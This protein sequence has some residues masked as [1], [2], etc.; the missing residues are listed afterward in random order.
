MSFPG[1]PRGSA[2]YRRLLWALFAVGIGMFAQLYAPQPILP[3]LAEDLGVSPSSAALTVSM[4]T[5]GLAVCVV[6]LSVLSDRLGR[7]RTITLGLA[8]GTLMGLLTPLAP[9]FELLLLARVLE[10]GLLGAVPAVTLAYLNEEVSRIDAA[11]AAGVYVAGSTIGGL[12]G[13]LIT[14]PLAEAFGWRAGVVA[15]ALLCGMATAAFRV[16]APASRRFTPSKLTLT[17]VTGRLKSVFTRRLVTLYLQGALLMGGFVG[18]Y[19][20]IS[21]RLT[22]DPFR[23]SSTV[24][25]F[26]FLAYLAGTV[27]SSLAGQLTS[28]VGRLPLLLASSAVMA[29][30]VVMTASAHLW[31]VIAGM[32]LTTGGY[33]AAHTTASA[34]AGF[35]AVGARA[36][37]ASVYNVF[38]YTGSSLFGWAVGLPFHAAGWTVA[39]AMV[40]VL[41]AAASSLALLNLRGEPAQPA[42]QSSAGA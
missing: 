2:E 8:G 35:E 21:F 39:A 15:V 5:M 26:I 17:Q 29:A 14:A 34:W 23:L 19:N 40:L 18:V 24:T 32:L 16:L 38:F 20:F 25:A 22:G 37:A 6:P 42:A 27:T 10:G 33:F 30:G 1:H 9:S 12:A 28:R 36:Q 7:V 13:R 41:I 31:L 4:A 3:L 11:R